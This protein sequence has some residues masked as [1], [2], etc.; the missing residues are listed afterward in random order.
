[1]RDSKDLAIR[2][3]IYSSGVAAKSRT[4]NECARAFAEDLCDI[5]AAEYYQRTGFSRL[6]N[7]PFQTRFKILILGGYWEYHHNQ[8]CF[9]N[10]FERLYGQGFATYRSVFEYHVPANLLLEY[11]L[12]IFSRCRSNNMITLL[13][14]CQEYDIPT[15]YMI[16]DNW[17]TLAKDHPKEG[18]IFVPGNPNYDNFIEALGLCKATWLFSDLLREDVLPFTRCVQKFKI[19]VDPH[20][21]EVSNPR[22]RDD[23]MLYV[24][25]SGSL[26]YDDAAFRALARYARRHSNVIIVLIG[27]L[28]P[29]QRL[30]F[31][32]VNTIRLAFQNYDRYAKNISYLRPDVLVAPLG[33][34]RTN[35]SKCYNKYIESGV[36]GAVG[37]YSKI[38][39]YTDI[40]EDDKNG[41]YVNEDTAEGWYKKLE[42]VL[43]DIPKLRAI[44]Y[45]VQRDVLE[46]HTVD[47][48]LIPFVEKITTIIREAG[49]KDD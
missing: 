47:V 44:Q 11:D 33:N 10:Y 32:N 49:L 7:A 25:F 38:K 21:F 39:P 29:T 27:D 15:M 26:R 35:Q 24:G 42:E 20:V 17:L 22:K 41:Y 6:G 37:I 1:M 19:S 43:S 36:I 31:K 46:Y 28:S 4:R 34:T 2:Y 45:A 8:V 9:F 16:D 48:L 3:A 40:V 5:D 23:N 13:H 12:V 14:F 18:G 30:L